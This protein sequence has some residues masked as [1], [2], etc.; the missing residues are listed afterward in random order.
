MALRGR[1]VSR[2]VSGVVF[3]RRSLTSATNTFED[4]Y[5]RQVGGLCIVDVVVKLRTPIVRAASALEIRYNYTSCA[6]GV[7]LDQL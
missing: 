3:S 7:K 5:C 6:L 2:N 4:D 1:G